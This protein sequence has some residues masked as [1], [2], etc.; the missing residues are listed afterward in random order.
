MSKLKIHQG[1]AIINFDLELASSN[2]AVKLMLRETVK[3][4]EGE[5]GFDPRKREPEF[6]NAA[7]SNMWDLV[8]ELQTLSSNKI[9]LF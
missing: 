8:S 1:A 3:T 5:A 6:A 9:T 7:L 4:K 2:R